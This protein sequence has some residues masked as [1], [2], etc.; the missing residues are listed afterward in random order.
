MTPKK[1]GVLLVV[2]LCVCAF[3]YFDLDRN[4][5]LLKLP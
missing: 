1:I 4:W 2:A 3:F 5:K